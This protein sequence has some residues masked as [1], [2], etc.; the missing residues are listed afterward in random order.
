MVTDPSSIRPSAL[1]ETS[2]A[3]QPTLD[4]MGIAARFKA[5][6]DQAWNLGTILRRRPE[7][8]RGLALM[9]CTAW[10]FHA[11]PATATVS[12]LAYDVDAEVLGATVISCLDASNSTF[13]LAEVVRLKERRGGVV[14]QSYYFEEGRDTVLSALSAGS[15]AAQALATVTNEEFDSPANGQGYTFRQYGVIDVEQGH[16]AFTGS[17]ALPVARAIHA[18]R[19]KLTY[20]IAGNILTHA[21]VLESLEDGLLEPGPH[22][23]QR[24][25]NALET[26]LES[27]GG[28]ERCA[29]RTSNRGF[30]TLMLS[31]GSSW[32]REVQSQTEDPAALL[33]TALKGQ[34]F[35]RP[36]EAEPPKPQPQPDGAA[37]HGCQH[38]PLA[39]RSSHIPACL[40]A[41]VLFFGVALRRH[42]SD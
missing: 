8:C 25:V 22:L 23:A 12:V 36:K 29:P 24:F 16:A 28:D 34:D 6:G 39:P 18:T 30:A 11:K 20:V 10:L 38:G 35:L 31:D 1:R 41:I 5:P 40:V 9:A 27:G 7:L 37:P 33:I 32:E 19:G 26:L 3:T 4:S 17:A 14:A 21:R 42:T 13:Q 15:T 2:K